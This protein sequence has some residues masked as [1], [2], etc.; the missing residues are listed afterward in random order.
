MATKLSWFPRIVL[1]LL[2]STQW[3]AAWASGSQPAP[4]SRAA[5]ILLPRLEPDTQVLRSTLEIVTV[6]TIGGVAKGVMNLGALVYQ[7][8]LPKLY[9]HNH[10]AANP[11]LP[12]AGVQS[13][14]F[15]NSAGEYLG[16]IS[17]QEFRALLATAQ[18]PGSALLDA[19]LP[20]RP[21]A[22]ARLQVS[23]IPVYA[24]LGDPGSLARGGAVSVPHRGAIG[25]S[26][27]HENLTVLSA[28]VEATDQLGSGAVPMFEL[29]TI[30][31]LALVGGDSG[32]P[33]WFDGQVVGNTWSL[34]RD[35]AGQ[36]T[37]IFWAAQAPGSTLA[38]ASHALN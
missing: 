2:A 11:D 19:P 6:S 8:G 22:L 16:Q 1:L 36:S 33:I 15:M 27:K 35:V 30:T 28:V 24:Q 10:Y 34:A 32:G 14:R 29:Q 18:D 23:Q 9:T 5:A 3:S 7:N 26:I 4:T 31:G 38:L 21:A 25:A 17:G 37:S 20:L 13:V 12:L